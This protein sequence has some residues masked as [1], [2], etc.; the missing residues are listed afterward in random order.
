MSQT[1]CCSTPHRT[2]PR[3]IPPTSAA[4]AERAIILGVKRDIELG[5]TQV[6][7]P[8]G[9]YADVALDQRL[10]REGKIKLRIYKALSAPGPA[11]LQLFQD[12]PIIDAND[13]RLNVRSLKLYADGS[14]GSRSAALLAPYS[15][16]PDTS[17]F[18]TIT[19]TALQPLLQAALKK[20]IQIETHAIGDRGNRFILDQYEKVNTVRVRMKIK[21]PRGGRAFQVA[22]GIP[23][24]T[25]RR[26]SIN[27]GFARDWRLHL[28]PAGG[29]HGSRRLRVG[30]LSTGSIIPGIAVEHGEPLIEFYAAVAKDLKFSASW[31]EKLSREQA[32]KM[33]PLAHLRT[34]FRTLRG[35]KACRLYCLFTGHEDSGEN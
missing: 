35:W 24:F 7:D 32:L 9:S 18:L 34:P 8:G 4:D 20:G 19:E 16:K 30:V 3:H 6:Q 11:A 14:L 12:G 26:D 10:Y 5:W 22:N 17:G 29:S 27:A 2:G 33:L 13:H 31:L 23:R 21:K 15:D 1:A 25:A 28:R